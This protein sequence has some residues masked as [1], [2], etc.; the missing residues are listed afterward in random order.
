MM[1]EQ[2]NISLAVTTTNS[3]LVRPRRLPLRQWA[4]QGTPAMRGRAT[5]RR[6]GTPLHSVGV[7]ARRDGKVTKPPTQALSTVLVRLSVQRQRVVGY[8]TRRDSRERPARIPA[9]RFPQQENQ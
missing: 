6:G 3:M 7:T 2:R 8:D 1:R 4:T 9:H 5:I